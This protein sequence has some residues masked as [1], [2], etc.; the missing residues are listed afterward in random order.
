MPIAALHSESPKPTFTD[1]A[2][3]P[4]PMI[5]VAAS[6]LGRGPAYVLAGESKRAASAAG[7]APAL[8]PVL[9]PPPCAD[10]PEGG[11]RDRRASPL[12]IGERTCLT[13]GCWG[14]RASLP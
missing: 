13:R 11:Q 14:S 10:P 1:P 3:R 6:E 8:P 9:T 2:Y 12:F 7:A 5:S 4:W